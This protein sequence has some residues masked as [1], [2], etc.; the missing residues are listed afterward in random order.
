MS[1][2]SIGWCV[3]YCILAVSGPGIFVWG[4]LACGIGWCLP[5]N[6]KRHAKVGFE[7]VVLGLGVPL[8]A[9]QLLTLLAPPPSQAFSINNN[10]GME[11]LR[12]ELKV[13]M[14]EATRLENEYDNQVS[15]AFGDGTLQPERL[16]TA[17]N[18][19]AALSKLTRLQ[20]LTDDHEKQICGSLQALPDRIERL[21]ADAKIKQ[22]FVDSYRESLPGNLLRIRSYFANEHQWFAAENQVLYF[23]KSRL[24]HFEVK[25]G[26][27]LFDNPDDVKTYNADV[28]LLQELAKKEQQLHNEL[29]SPTALK[30]FKDFLNG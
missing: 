21:P 19:D 2:K 8:L 10:A 27:F 22:Q 12:N 30:Q 11:P 13:L 25:D 7:C 28:Q 20:D 18:I 1:L 16:N 4:V 6:R 15:V 14:A 3:L 23:L 29:V 24:G 17:E 26:A 9:G 5:G